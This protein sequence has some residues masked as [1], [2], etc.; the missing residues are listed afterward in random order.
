MV[1]TQ[2][3]DTLAILGASGDLSARLLLP[4]IGQLLSDHPDRRFRLVG[5]GFEDWTDAHWRSV[6]RAS[7]ATMKASGPAVEEV[8]KETVYVQADVTQ[9]A[10]LERI[11]AACEGAPALYFALPPAITAKAC[12]VLG[13]MKLPRG[14]TPVSYTHLTLPTSCSACRSRGG[15]GQ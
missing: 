6:V 14:L 4:A 12:G 1:M 2:T 5:A 9:A 8:L 11:L 15:A 7:F 13:T 10:D 3:V